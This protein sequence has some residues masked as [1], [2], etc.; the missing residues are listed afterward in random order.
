MLKQLHP[1]CEQ[2]KCDKQRATSNKQHNVIAFGKREIHH[3][4]NIWQLLDND[5]SM[6]GEIHDCITLNQWLVR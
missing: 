5:N 2:V 4:E 1:F 3:I 6:C